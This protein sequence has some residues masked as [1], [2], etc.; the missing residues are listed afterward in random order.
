L[1]V[2]SDREEHRTVRQRISELIAAI[3]VLKAS[4]KRI[5]DIL[6]DSKKAV[7][8]KNVLK[9]IISKKSAGL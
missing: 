8:E 1:L 9:R 2:I 4:K 6:N 3:K 5:E 7:K